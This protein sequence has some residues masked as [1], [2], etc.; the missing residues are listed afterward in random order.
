[1]PH[2][3]ENFL[4]KH[5]DLFSGIGGFALAAQWTWKEQYE[6]VG[7]C[8]IE[9]F[10]CKVYHK[11]FPES[12]CLGDITKVKWNEG[13]A[14]LITGGFPCQDISASG[15]RIG[16]HGQ[17]S[18]LWFAMWETIRT[19][20]PK[21]V[22]GENVGELS[23][24]GLNEILAGLAEI[25][26]DV[27]WQDIRGS[28]V[29]APHKRERIWIVAHTKSL[30]W[31]YYRKTKNGNYKEGSL[32]QIREMGFTSKRNNGTD[33]WN[34]APAGAFRMDDGVP[35]RL[36]RLKGLG[37]AI[38]PQVAFEIFKRIKEVD[39]HVERVA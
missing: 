22:V 34:P 14:E 39:E 17:R 5:L 12:K 11:H 37:N 15:N 38:V 19:I 28:D 27:E 31:D 6:N 26:Y 21:Y 10:P 33:F 3:F 18:G 2:V 29:G 23:I 20:R 30:R 24:R 9:E 8:E 35:N 4:M 7:H 1:M 16:I 36:D 13:Q 32:E 25:G